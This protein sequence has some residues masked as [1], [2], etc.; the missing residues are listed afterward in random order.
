ML[1]EATEKQISYATFLLGKNGY[2]TTYMDKSYSNLG[3][4]MKERSGKVS[5]WLS[6]MDK[7]RIS[8]LIGGL[9]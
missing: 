1:K 4:T 9:L 3:A 8:D 6:N 2:D 7:A 5:T